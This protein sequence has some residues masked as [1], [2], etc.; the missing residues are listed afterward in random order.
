MTSNTPLK[1]LNAMALEEE[2]TMTLREV[3]ATLAESSA[4]RELSL[5]G[6]PTEIQQKLCVYLDYN[7]LAN[8]RATCRTLCDSTTPETKKRL[9]RELSQAWT[10]V[11]N[12][13]KDDYAVLHSRIES[14]EQLVTQMQVFN[15]AKSAGYSPTIANWLALPC[16]YYF[17]C[18]QC[19]YI[20]HKQVFGMT[21]LRS[22]FLAEFPEPHSIPQSH[23]EFFDSLICGKCLAENTPGRY[24]ALGEV[25]YYSLVIN[26]T[27]CKEIDR[28]EEDISFRVKLSSF[29]ERC[30]MMLNPEW[31]EYKQWIHETMQAIRE[32]EDQVIVTDDSQRR[33]LPQCPLNPESVEALTTRPYHFMQNDRQKA[34][35]AK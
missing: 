16:H 10:D 30:F 12:V 3:D 1:Q 33:P 22:S 8:L 26:C 19:G 29:C 31:Y 20:R 21:T 35:E 9:K 28:V 11:G 17:P 18:A 24:L 7:D 34:R 4:G 14:Q 23:T 27:E 32:I 13:F 6:L 25:D 5:T 15:Y 2:A